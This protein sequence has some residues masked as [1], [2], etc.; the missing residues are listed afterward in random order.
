LEHLYLKSQIVWAV[1]FLTCLFISRKSAKTIL[2]G[3]FMAMPLAIF[4]TFYPRSWS[5]DYWIPGFIGIEDVIFCFLMGGISTAL[6]LRFFG[7]EGNQDRFWPDI[8]RTLIIGLAGMGSMAI[9]FYLGI[10]EYLQSYVSMGFLSG[11]LIL[12]HRDLWKVFLTAAF[13]FMSV[14]LVGVQTAFFV[15][16]GLIHLWN[17]SEMS[18]ILAGHTPLEE[19]LWAWLFGGTW[20]V[21][22][23]YITDHSL[24]NQS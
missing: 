4:A 8:R 3:A 2:L 12:L 22:L 23:L 21:T 7:P 11:L 17:L 6:A 19:I 10:Q 24:G 15:W 5:P 9:L 14:Y 13:L 18:G 16:P 1:I 20:S